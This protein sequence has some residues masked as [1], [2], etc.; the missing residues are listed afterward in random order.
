MQRLSMAR[1]LSGALL[2]IALTLAVITGLG[3]AALYHARQTYEDRLSVTS[4]LEVSAANL[5]AAGI[6][7]ETEFR[8]PPAARNPLVVK[9]ATDA[10]DAAAARAGILARGAPDPA[11]DRYL[12]AELR[13]ERA[14]RRLASRRQT[15]PAARRTSRLIAVHLTRARR[16]AVALAARQSV[17][18]D[19][20]RRRA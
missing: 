5:L 4:A 2:G 16:A 3:I 14:A 8:Q 13:A 7:E 12:G 17:R 15:G 10:Y 9:R 18:R 20:A 19:D 11:T 6:V 1:V